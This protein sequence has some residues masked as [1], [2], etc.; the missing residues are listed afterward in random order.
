MS[1]QLC[2]LIVH[3]AS[4]RVRPDVVTYRLAQRSA[5]A[6]SDLVTLLDTEGGGD[7]GG[8]VLVSLLVSGV[9]G[10]EVEVLAAD[11]EGTVHL[12]R[13][14]G[15]GQDTTADGDEAGEGAL[16]VCWSMWLVIGPTS[17]SES[18]LPFCIGS[19]GFLIPSIVR[20]TQSLRRVP[21]LDLHYVSVPAR[22]DP[23]SL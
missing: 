23:K 6:N 1:C 12:G 2:V 7:V 10:D 19:L 21:Y 11:D 3:F 13:H 18:S 20:A 22:Q 16:L 5:L 14:D 9:L 17:C 4:T 15:A 8:Q